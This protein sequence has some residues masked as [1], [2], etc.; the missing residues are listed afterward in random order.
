MLAALNDRTQGEPLCLRSLF[1]LIGERAAFACDCR[2]SSNATKAQEFPLPN[3]PTAIVFLFLMAI[4]AR[5]SRGTTTTTKMDN[6]GGLL[7]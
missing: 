5:S 7:T 6:V 3:H 2:I 1:F 4:R